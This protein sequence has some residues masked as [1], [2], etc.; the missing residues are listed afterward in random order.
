MDK[1]VWIEDCFH[2]CPGCDRTIWDVLANGESLVL[3]P[4]EA[5]PRDL[6][7]GH[8]AGLDGFTAYCLPCHTAADR[9]Q[10]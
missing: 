9:S 5:V 7:S 3:V 4:G 10:P 6:V 2:K 8:G 1:P